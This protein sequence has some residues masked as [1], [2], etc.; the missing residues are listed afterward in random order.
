ML[1]SAP[2]DGVSG[3]KGIAVKI[4]GNSHY[5]NSCRN[6]GQVKSECLSVCD[7]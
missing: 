1:P 3:D 7:A 4:R 2:Q 5:R 6:F